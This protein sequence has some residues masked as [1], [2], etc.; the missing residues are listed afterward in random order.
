MENL[1]QLYI[2][3]LTFGCGK[4]SCSNELCASNP[5]FHLPP[6]M[7]PYLAATLSKMGKKYLCEEN[8]NDVENV[9]DPPFYSL[10]DFLALNDPAQ[11]LLTINSLF[12]SKSV[13]SSFTLHQFDYPCTSFVH[14]VYETIQGGGASPSQ[15]FSNSHST[16]LDCATTSSLRLIEKIQ[17][18]RTQ[19]NIKT[20]GLFIIWFENPILQ[21]E[22]LSTTA[23]MFLSGIFDIFAKMN[24]FLLDSLK[25][26]LLMSWAIQESKDVDILTKNS[27]IERFVP[28]YRSR[29][30]SALT[31]YTKI[32]QSYLTTHAEKLMR[33]VDAVLN[34]DTQIQ[35]ATQFLG[36]LCKY[37]IL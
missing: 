35:S 28:V 11:L 20:L 22:P 33:R 7:F 19:L 6:E 23:D 13:G 32:V 27:S 37:L 1:E 31:K 29:L 5:L 14:K 17:K 16:F 25:N 30:S 34:K 24:D 36:L 26:V 3:Q 8:K 10:D 12:S 9:S 2:H 21:V 4:T 18:E 15:E